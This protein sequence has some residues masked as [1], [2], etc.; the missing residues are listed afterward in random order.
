M[1]VFMQKSNFFFFKDIL[2]STV[3][4][5]ETMYKL[6]QNYS[7]LRLVELPD[8]AGLG[9]VRY[10]PEAWKRDDF[11]EANKDE[12]N[13]LNLQIV[14]QLRNTDSAFSAG[15]FISRSI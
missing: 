11:M 1:L 8:W 9:G 10:V 3:A 2:R 6:I 5:K 13:R 4:Q 15:K 7:C 12:L 14:Q